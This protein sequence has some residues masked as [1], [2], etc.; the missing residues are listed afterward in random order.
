MVRDAEYP[1]SRPR[2]AA[3]LSR[4]APNLDHH[5]ARQLLGESVVAHEIAHAQALLEQLRIAQRRVIGHEPVRAACEPSIDERLAREDVA[6]AVMYAIESAARTHE[7]YPATPVT[8]SYAR[9][10]APA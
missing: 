7:D 4:A 3:E 10:P 2:T 5:V 6:F 9:T 1:C 8:P